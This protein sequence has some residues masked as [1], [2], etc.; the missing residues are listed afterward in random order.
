MMTFDYEKVI[1]R[2][3]LLESQQE[4]RRI[5]SDY[6]SLCD[7]L[8]TLSCAENI[9]QLFTE[10]AVWEGVGE[11]YQIKLGRVAG[12]DAIRDMMGK[13]VKSPAHFKVNVHFLCSEHIDIVNYC[14]A[15][16][17]WKMLQ[18]STFNDGTSHLNS[19]ELIVDFVFKGA[20][21]FIAHFTTRN[22]FSRPVSYWHSKNDFSLPEE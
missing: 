3:F 13:Y 1:A 20:G 18:T 12:R 19:A 17:R 6:M 9:S 8:Q 22:L 16:G 2:I 10:D 4:I 14:H 11:L 5:M 21:W 15:K 7:D